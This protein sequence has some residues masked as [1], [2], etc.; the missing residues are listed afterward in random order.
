MHLLGHRKAIHA[1]EVNRLT[2][3]G[4]GE[5]LRIGRVGYGAD[6]FATVGHE[7]VVGIV[8]FVFLEREHVGAAATADLRSRVGIFGPAHHADHERF[9][10]LRQAPAANPCVRAIDGRRRGVVLRRVRSRGRAFGEPLRGGVGIERLGIGR[11]REQLLL[12]VAQAVSVAV[13][14]RAAHDPRIEHRVERFGSGERL[15]ARH[16]IVAVVR[17]STDGSDRARPQ[18]QAAIEVRM[19]PFIEEGVKHRT[20]IDQREAYGIVGTRDDVA[21]FIVK[22]IAV[23]GCR[24]AEQRV[25]AVEELVIIVHAVHIGIGHARIGGNIAYH[26]LVDKQRSGNREEVGGIAEK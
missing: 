15:V 26:R 6:N 16:P 1:R 7:V 3:V 19:R 21:V 12:K 25:E 8:A 2:A 5:I 4:V 9:I 11:V 18:R 14:V 23:A 22:Q 10:H 13:H 17:E 24:L 20:R